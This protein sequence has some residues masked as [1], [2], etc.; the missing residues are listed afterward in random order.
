MATTEQI[1]ALA[2]LAYASQTT[3]VSTAEYD[4]AKLA[5]GLDPEDRLASMR[6]LES[7]G[8]APGSSSGFYANSTLNNAPLDRKS[9]CRERV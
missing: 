1:Q 6:L 4:A 2:D 9:A 7:Y 5:A 8:Y 3:G